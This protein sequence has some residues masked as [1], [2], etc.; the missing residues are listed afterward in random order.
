[1]A[2]GNW[3]PELVSLAGGLP[4]LGQ[5]GRSSSWITWNDLV[6]ADPE[7]IVLMPCGYDIAQTAH[8]STAL[9]ENA[10]WSLLRAVKTGQVYVADGNQYFNRPGPRLIDSVE[11][12]AEIFHPQIIPPQHKGQGWQPLKDCVESQLLTTR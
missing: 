3:V 12:L 8:E 7:V 4:M 1:M 11:I 10:H 6:K 5:T 9:F 2:A